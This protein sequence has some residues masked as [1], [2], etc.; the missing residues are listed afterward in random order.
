MEVQ[1]PEPDGRVAVAVIGVGEHG[2]HH[3][4]ALSGIPG[5]RLAGVYDLS[6]ERTKEAAAELG[7]RAFGSLEEALD[8]VQAAS[9]VI[10]TSEHAAA[11]R[12]ALD[13]GVDVLLEKPITR[14][15]EEA[16]ELVERAVAGRRILQVGHLERFN[17]GVV[18]ARAITRQPLF[19]EIHRLGVFSARSLDVDVVFD[20]MI[21]D[22]DLVLWMVD[23]P[24]SD[25]RAVGL[26]V[27]SNKVDIANARVEFK[28]GAVANLT[29]SRA[30]TERVRKFRYFQPNEYISIDF[31]R[32]DAIALSVDRDGP[33]P[34]IAFRKL[35]TP[36]D[37][38]DSSLA[39]SAKAAADPLRAELEAFVSS[40]RTRRPPLVGGAEGRAALAL[41]ERVMNCIEEHAAQLN[42][43]LG[44]SIGVAGE[45]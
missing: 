18:A 33:T 2:R 36:D 42:I 44:R 38:K 8:G 7:V 10:P 13:A 24:V 34:H 41:A 23:S 22:L 28:N 17:P 32:R 11:A 30:S 43:P 21:H 31:A 15:V 20:L 4:R 5:A 35:E 12:E 14:T 19:F 9:I 29:A 26:P 45:L 40:V 37:S 16:D 39:E 3:A 25:V 1:D 6:A 27:L